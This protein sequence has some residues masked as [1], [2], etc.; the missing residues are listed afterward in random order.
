MVNIEVHPFPGH[1]NLYAANCEWEK[2]WWGDLEVF[3]FENGRIRWRAKPAGGW[4][5]GE[6]SILSLRPLKLPQSDDPFVEMFGKTHMGH[7]NYYLLHLRRRRLY[8]V[9]DTF[10]VDF[11]DD[12][13]LIRNGS[14][15]PNYRDL[16]GD[17]ATDVELTGMIETKV[18]DEGRISVPVENGELYVYEFTEVPRIRSIPCRKVF[19]WDGRLRTFIEDRQQ[20][21]GFDELY[22]YRHSVSYDFDE[23][24]WLTRARVVIDWPRESNQVIDIEI[25]RDVSEVQTGRLPDGGNMPWLGT[26][27]LVAS[28]DLLPHGV[29]E[30]SWF[31]MRTEP[32]S[33]GE[34]TLLKQYMS[35]GEDV[36]AV[37]ALVFKNTYGRCFTLCGRIHQ[38]PANPREMIKDLGRASDS[39][40]L[41]AAL[42]LKPRE[43]VRRLVSEL[44]VIHPEPFSARAAHMAWTLNA[45]Y[46]ITRKEFS[47]KTAGP[48]PPRWADWWPAGEPLP[49]Y[50]TWMSRGRDV[51]AP[52]DVQE[53]VVQ[54]WVNWVR[55]TGTTFEPSA[56]PITFS[57]P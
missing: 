27:Y 38:Q 5:K 9:I 45:L 52:R 54:A 50:G 15:S 12:Q 46:S 22:P 23:Q 51:I 36:R 49:Y 19:I 53:K 37:W 39:N 56:E 20:R 47:F 42:H 7:G 31:L 43:S 13:H 40:R 25:R 8:P 6:Q 44:N 34:L 11:H 48:F 55:R 17:G 29:D 10:A 57:S 26:E 16:N 3:E 21:E 28:S 4:E 14:L 32:F 18:D 33:N 2:D 35:W 30:N 1:E 41:V 24:E